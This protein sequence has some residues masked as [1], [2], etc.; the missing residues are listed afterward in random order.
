M[1]DFLD[2]VNNNIEYIVGIP[3]VSAAFALV[4]RWSVNKLTKVI[5]PWVETIVVKTIGQFFGGE[6]PEDVKQLPIV[7]QMQSLLEMNLAIAEMELI[8]LKKETVN[9]L[10]SEQERTVFA[11]MFSSLYEIYKDKI[12]EETKQ[13]LGVFE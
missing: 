7:K 10:Y 6:K 11:A 3:A 5:I 8:R 2:L 1:Q 12:S 4:A 9:P 13:A